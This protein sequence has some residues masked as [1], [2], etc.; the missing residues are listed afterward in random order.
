MSVSHR[1]TGG[2]LGRTGKHSVYGTLR[3]PSLGLST[4]QW[5]PFRYIFFFL[6]KSSLLLDF[7]GGPLVANPPTN[8]GDTGS[9]PGLRRFH[10][11]QGNSARAPQLL[12]LSPGACV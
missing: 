1:V 4:S 2:D 6:N 7:P 11:V 5:T 3:D 10:A 8:A 9:I 12:S